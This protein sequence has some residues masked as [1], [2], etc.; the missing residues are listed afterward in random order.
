[1]CMEPNANPE[2]WE[3]HLLTVSKAPRQWCTEHVVVRTLQHHGS[4]LMV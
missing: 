4:A 3:A 2:S 1:M